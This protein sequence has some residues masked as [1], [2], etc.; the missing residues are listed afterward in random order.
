MRR[1]IEFQS[2]TLVWQFADCVDIGMTLF[3]EVYTLYL[4]VEINEILVK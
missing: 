1:N 3:K 2:R 4:F